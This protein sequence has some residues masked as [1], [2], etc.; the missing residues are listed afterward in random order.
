MPAIQV[1]ASKDVIRHKQY[2]EAASD[3]I[4]ARLK[5]NDKKLYQEMKNERKSPTKVTLTMNFQLQLVQKAVTEAQVF[6]LQ[7]SLSWS[8]IQK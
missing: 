4:S 6:E 1:L 7:I 5:E 3:L 2:A 8:S